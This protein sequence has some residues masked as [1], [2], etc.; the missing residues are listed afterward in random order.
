MHLTRQEAS[1]LLPIP[2]K[3]TKYV[4]RAL[5]NSHNSVPV[6]IALRDMLGIAQN[7]AEVKN[8]IHRK[9]V[10]LNGRFVKERNEGIKLFNIFE[11]G[12]S[13]ILTLSQTGTF[14]F[15]EIK[16]ASKRLC[17]V[18]NKGIVKG[19]KVQLHLH[20][21]STI[22]STQKISPGD[23]VYLDMNGKIVK[24]VPLSKGA[25]AFIISGKY[26]GSEGVVENVEGNKIVVSFSKDKSAVLE[27]EAV[28]VR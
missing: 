25:S 14:T 9:L 17:S 15:N 18:S 6:V 13:F 4:A 26:A 12:K 1:T 24:H 11:A 28:F 16:D 2:R 20:D 27:R 19:G 7:S 23:S 21:G 10:K 5:H 8:L 22:I 3:G